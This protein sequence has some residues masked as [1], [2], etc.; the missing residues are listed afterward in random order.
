MFGA[1]PK[2]TKN[3]LVWGEGGVVT[4]GKDS[5]IGDKGTCM[6]FVGYAERK[7]NSVRMWDPSAMRVV[8]TQ[9][10]ILL[11]RLYFQPD[12]VPGVLELDTAD[13]FGNN[14]NMPV[15]NNL[16]L[17]SGGAVTWSDPVV[18]EPTHSGVTRSGHIIKTLERLTYAPAIE[19]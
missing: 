13:N 7:S 18:T 5:K 16:P 9:D 1:N 8:V 6:M 14:G 19:L 4:V 11:K 3:L 15:P 2:W 10:I 17:Q 12:N